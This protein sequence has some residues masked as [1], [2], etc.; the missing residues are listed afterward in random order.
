MPRQPHAF[1]LDVEEPAPGDDVEVGSAADAEESG[2]SGA[3]LRVCVHCGRA[4]S[5]RGECTHDV[6]AAFAST[7]AAVRAAVARLRDA[8]ALRAK[9]ERALR[10]LLASERERG[11]AEL[12]VHPGAS[13]AL[14]APDPP[15]PEARPPAPGPPC[16][17]CA[18]RDVADA[19]AATVATAPPASR[20]GR[21]R[22]ARF[23]GAEGQAWFDFARQPEP[24]SEP[25]AGP[26]EP[27]PP[28][29]SAAPGSDDPRQLPLPR[30]QP[31]AEPAAASHL[32]AVVPRGAD[33]GAP[34]PDARGAVVPAPPEPEGA[35]ERGSVEVPAETTALPAA[36]PPQDAVEAS[37]PAAPAGRRKR[38]AGRR[39][40]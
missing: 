29:T 16:A 38:G 3:R 35:R 22:G 20:V 6:V 11:R 17:R 32:D 40:G 10:A 8:A 9:A 7:T 27:T 23:A 21:K 31:R 37:A 15:P 28:R 4:A 25:S 18:A 26:R 5:T 33:D 39:A 12:E 19:L 14:V 13:S 1:A 24:P 34:A 2:E 36:E 30:A